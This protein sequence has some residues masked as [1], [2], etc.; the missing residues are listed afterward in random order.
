MRS[1][2]PTLIY[3]NQCDIKATIKSIA[4]KRISPDSK[5][6]PDWID[7]CTNY[8]E[9]SIYGKKHKLQGFDGVIEYFSHRVKTEFVIMKHLPIDT[10][11]I[12]NDLNDWDDIFK[13]ISV[14]ISTKL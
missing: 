12:D 14:H 3:L 10:I 5:M 7:E 6:M 2:D 1:L 11:I 13:Q 9:K 4:L 8:V